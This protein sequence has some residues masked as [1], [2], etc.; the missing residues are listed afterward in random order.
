ML[1]RYSECVHKT[2]LVRVDTSSKIEATNYVNNA[3]FFVLGVQEIHMNELVVLAFGQLFT[4]SRNIAPVE[5]YD[6]IGKQ[7]LVFL[8]CGKLLG[9]RFGHVED[10]QPCCETSNKGRS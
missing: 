9:L 8:R 5:L 4:N 2:C 3:K 1:T 6:L 10:L 7:F